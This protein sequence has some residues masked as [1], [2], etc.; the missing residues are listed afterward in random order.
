MCA[1][2]KNSIV[3]D[4]CENVL[5]VSLKVARHGGLVIVC[6]LECKSFLVVYERPSCF[7]PG[8]GTLVSW[9][10]V[11]EDEVVAVEL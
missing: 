10:V 9:V 2:L 1:Y 3:D 7:R 5:V 8:L 6:D 11:Y 4:G